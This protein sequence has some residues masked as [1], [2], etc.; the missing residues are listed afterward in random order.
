MQIGKRTG[1]LLTHC[2]Q[3]L[4]RLWK[5][6]SGKITRDSEENVV[7]LREDAGKGT[8][9][10]VGGMIAGCQDCRHTHANKCKT[11]LQLGRQPGN[12]YEPSHR[13]RIECPFCCGGGHLLS[14]PSPAIHGFLF[15]QSPHAPDPTLGGPHCD[16][17]MCVYSK[18][19][20]VCRARAASKPLTHQWDL[21][22][23][24]QPAQPLPTS[25]IRR[26]RRPSSRMPSCEAEVV[27]GALQA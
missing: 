7:K 17:F 2:L 15:S 14:N 13:H 26:L 6:C 3:T 12:P 18:E 19:C 20:F 11:H 16:L 8:G 10:N 4:E 27:R 22:K 21:K 1:R 25:P 5:D 9:Q 23:Q 24:V